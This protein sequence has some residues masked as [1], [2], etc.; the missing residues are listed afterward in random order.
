[1][2]RAC[3]VDARVAELTTRDE[4]VFHR[5]FPDAVQFNSELAAVISRDGTISFYDPGTAYCPAGILAWEKEAVPALIHGRGGE[6]PFAETPVSDAVRNVRERRY[7]ANIR[8]DGSIAGNVELTFS[9]QRAIEI[10]NEL[11]DL[12]TDERATRIRFRERQ[13]SPTIDVPEASI[14]VTDDNDAR[15]AFKLKYDLTLPDVAVRTEKRL[16]V[17]P[18]M[19][20]ASDFGA[21]GSAKRNNALF[22]RYGWTDSDTIELTVPPGYSVE[23]LPTPIELDAGALRYRVTF[24]F[25]GDKLFCQRTLSVRAIYLAPEQ[26]AAAKTFFDRVKQADATAVTLIQRQ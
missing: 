17:T 25:A 11:S 22:L 4:A 1:M 26:Y 13:A 24:A 10:R 23:Q 6:D 14:T 15:S 9:G 21:F 19:L 8:M 7:S 20:A 2:L 5:Y 18:T 16:L 12:T 3:G